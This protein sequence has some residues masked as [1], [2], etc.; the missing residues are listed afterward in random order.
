MARLPVDDAALGAGPSVCVAQVA[1]SGATRRPF[2]RLG[3]SQLE[4]GARDHPAPEALHALRDDADGR[5]W[6]G[7]L[8][9]SEKGALSLCG[10]I[11]SACLRPSNPCLP[12]TVYG[13]LTFNTLVSCL[14]LWH[15]TLP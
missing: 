13:S 10:G 3:A 1:R 7:R 12:T 15:G 8:Q 6:N 9:A 14:A 5:R 4:A 11:I 2:L